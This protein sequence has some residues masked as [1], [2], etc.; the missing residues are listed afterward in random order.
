MTVRIMINIIGWQPET[1]SSDNFCSTIEIFLLDG[2]I[3]YRVYMG[4][5]KR[6]NIDVIWCD[7]SFICFTFCVREN[8]DRTKWWKIANV[9][10][11]FEWPMLLHCALLLYSGTYSLNS[12]C[13]ERKN[14]A[15]SSSD[16]AV[17]TWK[18]HLVQRPSLITYPCLDGSVK[19]IVC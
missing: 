3:V 8:L 13:L 1:N 12:S 7:L 11:P 5:K 6:R 19:E 14:V 2:I 10:F 9:F 18:H 4:R 16:G 15:L 17:K